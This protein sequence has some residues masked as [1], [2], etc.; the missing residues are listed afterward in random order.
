LYEEGKTSGRVMA[1]ALHPFV[2]GQPHRMPAL[3]RALDY[4]CG[5][6]G[7]WKTTGAEIALHFLSS[8][9]A[10]IENNANIRI[11]LSRSGGMI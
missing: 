5:F 11:D 2:M 6:D 3:A 8:Q 1:I 7:V 9:A 10:G 4:I